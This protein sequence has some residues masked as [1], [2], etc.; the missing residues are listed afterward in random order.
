MGIGRV[1]LIDTHVWIWLNLSP[2]KFSVSAMKT[3][4]SAPRIVLSAIS[5]YETMVAVEKGRIATSYS[6]ED[7]VRRWLKASDIV[8]VPVQEEILIQSRALDFVHEDPFDRII[9]STAVSEQIPLLTA[10]GNL[11]KLG[12]LATI[13]AQ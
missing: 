8:R 4:Q 6:A 7:L 13:P 11:L 10:D 1:I 2:E 5:I 12:W 3:L 9:A